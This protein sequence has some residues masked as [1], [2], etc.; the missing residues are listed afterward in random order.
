MRIVNANYE[1]KFQSN[2]LTS[3]EMRTVGQLTGC[4]YK[5]PLQIMNVNLSK[6]NVNR[7][8]HANIDHGGVAIKCSV[9]YGILSAEILLSC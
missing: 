2:G 5:L 3:L 7:E 6:P 4:E 9:D 1:F 8:Q